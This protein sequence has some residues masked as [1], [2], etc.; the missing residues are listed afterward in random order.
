MIKLHE[1]F[2]AGLTELAPADQVDVVCDAF[3]VAWNDTGSPKIEDYLDHCDPAFRELLLAELLLVD[4]EF[5]IKGGESISRESYRQRFPDFSTVID[6]LDFSTIPEHDERTLAD[7]IQRGITVGSKLAHFELLEEVGAGAS[8]TVWKAYD[9]RL[10]RIV[11]LKIPRFRLTALERERFEREGQACAQLRHPRI[12]TVFEVGT[13]EQTP[14]I[15]AE[16][17]EGVDLRDWL[18]EHRPTPQK[19][20]EFAA[21][22][23]EALHHAHEH[24]V[25][26]RDLKPANIL[27]DKNGRLHIT[28]FG[29]A[30]WT[31]Q[32]SDLTF[33][34]NIL[35]TPAYMSPEQARGNASQ[36]D[37]RTDVYGLGAIFYEMLTGRPP[38]QGELA[39]ILPQV[40]EDEPVAPRKIDGTV[41]RDL[42]TI[43]LVSLEK[44]AAQR[45][46]STHDMAEDLQRFLRGE[47]IKARRANLLEISWR[48]VKRRKAMFGLLIASVVAIA[49]LGM[50]SMLAQKNHDLMGYQRVT[51]TTEPPGARV[52]FV[53]LNKTTGELELNRRILSRGLSPVEQDLLPGDYLIASV[54]QNGRF[55]EVY[56]HV[57]GDTSQ[58]PGAFKHRFWK[59]SADGTLTLPTIVIPAGSVT[60]DMAFIRGKE[61]FTAG[62]DNS[63]ELPAHQRSIDS[64]YMDT[65]EFTFGQYRALC[66][67]L[68][69][70]YR[71]DPPADD[72]PVSFNYDEALAY[73]EKQ[74]KR[75]P[76]EFEYEFAASLPP[77]SAYL[78]HNN[79][80]D[81]SQQATLVSHD[82]DFQDM[83]P[84]EP[85]ILGLRT[86]KAEWTC[87]WAVPYSSAY[88]A[89][90]AILSSEYRIVRGGDL[91]RTNDDAASTSICDLYQRTA[92]SRHQA[93]EG[94]GFRC[95]RS[96]SPLVR[97][98]EFPE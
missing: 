12:V 23:A 7:N 89:T 78:S 1:P 69:K 49:S 94:L 59:K 58:L 38:F 76:T 93:H 56:R 40:L 45:Y 47:S 50:A 84:T 55:H 64:F 37:C 71:V 19:S 41:P 90:E 72:F 13:N 81:E 61:D 15:A 2:A 77:E 63:K 5:R 82:A 34:G 54:M 39:T 26:H 87:S 9:A 29:L 51:I 8:G 73:A 70:R 91:A 96:A 24:N 48:L 80:R 88:P 30:K 11:A 22:M 18:K 52:A 68:P 86:G 28:D 31:T 53:P 35:G 20:A 44:D 43:C 97:F 14:F 67:V 57:P 4:R 83:L 85:S 25:I 75:L 42:E 79:Q 95:V 6:G 46:Q 10:R 66:K 3:E 65:T 27:I 32:G 33:E 74:G 92:L 60:T 16:F 36:V 17:I 62:I 21:Q 98:D